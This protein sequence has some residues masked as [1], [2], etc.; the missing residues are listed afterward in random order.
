MKLL[1]I[2]DDHAIATSLITSLQSQ[3]Q[4]DWADTIRNAETEYSINHYDCIIA[5]L[6]LPDGNG[7]EFCRS[8]RTAGKHTPLVII[9]GNQGENKKIESLLTG[10]DDYLT[11][12]FLFSELHARIHA[13]LRRGTNYIPDILTFN[14]VTID[15]IHRTF[16]IGNNLLSLTRKEFDLL[17]FL[18]ERKN[19]PVTITA[20]I[21]SLWDSNHEP[22]SNTIEVHI[23][24][25][26]Q[27]FRAAQ[28]TLSIRT[29]KNYGYLLHS[30]T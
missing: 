24:R 14:N 13:V 2:E 5:D 16:A 12:P 10:A 20:L 29:L 22:L 21:E 3:Y 15:R 28:S 26:R 30:P 19:C 4:V 23:C 17:L 25:L 18:A 6:Q 27:K 7:M 1:L 8:L 9:T 11:K